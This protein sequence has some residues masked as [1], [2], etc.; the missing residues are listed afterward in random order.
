MEYLST[1]G[2]W[3]PFSSQTT[4]DTATFTQ[5][6][7]NPNNSVQPAQYR[8]IVTDINLGC[9]AQS[10]ITLIEPSVLS[11]SA[12]STSTTSC[13]SSDGTVSV[14]VL[15]GTGPYTYLWN[16]SSSS[17]TQTVTNL[18]VGTYIV[19]VTDANAC[20]ITD[21][22]IVASS[23]GNLS[24]SIVQLSPILCYGL[25]ATVEVTTLCGSGWYV[26]ELQYWDPM[27]GGLWLPF[28]TQTTYGT[29]TFT[30]IPANSW[31]IVVTDQS[32]SNT[33][34]TSFTINE[35]Q[36]LLLSTTSTSA[37]CANSCDGTASTVATGGT[38]P[39]SYIWSNE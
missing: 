31:R 37:S 32:N 17:I 34:I 1:F 19:T 5:I 9:V 38:L 24:A 18:S 2:L 30:Q 35:P 25:T 14:S 27:F 8:I 26:Y 10:A 11:T 21:T 4:N 20:S 22:A 15:G 28:S 7:G 12:S 16:D 39:Y 33:A 6:L 3:L 23:G 13:N 29:A 36:P